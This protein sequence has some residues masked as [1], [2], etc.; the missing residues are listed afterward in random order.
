MALMEREEHYEVTVV[1]WG[2]SRRHNHQPVV[3]CGEVSSFYQTTLQTF[4]V[5]NRRRRSTVNPIQ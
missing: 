4:G 1:A 5:A 3:G 2:L